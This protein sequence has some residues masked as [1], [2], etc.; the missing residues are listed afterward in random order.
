[1]YQGSGYPHKLNSEWA[2]LSFPFP[3]T[4]PSTSRSSRITELQDSLWSPMYEHG[5][6]VRV[7]TDTAERSHNVYISF[8]P[9]HNPATPIRIILRKLPAAP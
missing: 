3:S 2:S 9:G 8:D 7:N 4:S 5:G 1:M 6:H